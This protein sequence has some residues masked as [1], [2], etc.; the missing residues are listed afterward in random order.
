M[1]N[2]TLL[3]GITLIP[4]AGAFAFV[5]GGDGGGGRRVVGHC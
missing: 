5:E 3:H 2:D 1:R 4:E